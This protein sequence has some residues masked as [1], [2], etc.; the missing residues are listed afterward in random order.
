MSE[1]TV[2]LPRNLPAELADLGPPA[3][4]F[5]PDSEKRLI[6][7]NVIIAVA[8]GVAALGFFAV[9]LNFMGVFLLPGQKPPPRGVQVGVGLVS[10]P[11]GGLRPRRGLLVARHRGAGARS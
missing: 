8:A 10:T 9:G 11:L 3:E 4:V 5:A 6:L 7:V 2:E 1:Q